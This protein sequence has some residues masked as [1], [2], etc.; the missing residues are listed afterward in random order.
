MRDLHRNAMGLGAAPLNEV[1]D[2]P[3]FIGSFEPLGGTPPSSND[4]AEW[5]ATHLPTVRLAH[6]MCNRPKANL[7]KLAEPER[8]VLD[9]IIV[10]LQRTRLEMMEHWF[11]CE[12]ALA[13]LSI[14]IGRNVLPED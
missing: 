9:A 7:V 2:Q 11:T 14:V 4:D 3:G 13:R 5:A 6:M 8:D 12:A 1:P 10:S